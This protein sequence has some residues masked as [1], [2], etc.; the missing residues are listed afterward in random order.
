[1]ADEIVHEYNFNVPTAYLALPIFKQVLANGTDTTLIH[2]VYCVIRNRF[3][4]I[5]AENNGFE[6][7]QHIHL[8]IFLIMI[9]F[10]TAD[11]SLYSYGQVYTV[12]NDAEDTNAIKVSNWY[13]NIHISYI[14][15][16]CAVI[17]EMF[18]CAVFISK[19]SQPPASRVS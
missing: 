5:T 13:R 12:T 7:V 14:T 19:K 9:L 17:L 6:R 8:G 16:Y 11:A 1:M 3:R 2:V 18:A 10:A 15:V 4:S